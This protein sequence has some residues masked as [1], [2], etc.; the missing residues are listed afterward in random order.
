MN[1]SLNNSNINAEFEVELKLKIIIKL[2]SISIWIFIL[3]SS[4]FLPT[5]VRTADTITTSVEDIL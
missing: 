2:W 1:H 3:V 5:G 4:Y